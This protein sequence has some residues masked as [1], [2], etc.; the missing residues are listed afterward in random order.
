[1]CHGMKK[2]KTT[3]LGYSWAQFP[4]LAVGP[5]NGSDRADPLHPGAFHGWHL[6]MCNNAR[7]VAFGGRRGEET[8]KELNISWTVLLIFKY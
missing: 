7:P 4:L 3:G 6:T 2:L 5:G 8:G 1:M